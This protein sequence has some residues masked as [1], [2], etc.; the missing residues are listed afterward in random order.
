VVSWCRVEWQ[1]KQHTLDL[2]NDW[3]WHR[4]KIWLSVEPFGY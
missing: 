3:N 1:R 4:S 2:A